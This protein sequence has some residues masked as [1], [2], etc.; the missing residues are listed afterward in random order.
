M[1]VY[2]M[3]LSYLK[4]TIMTKI[5]FFF[6][7][8][9]FTHS[10]FSQTT[11]NPTGS[12]PADRYDDVYFVSPD[13][14]WAVG[15]SLGAGRI[16]HTTNGGATWQVQKT[17]NSY[18]R[19]IEFADKN[20][21]Y[22]GALGQSSTNVL[23][24][25]SDGG[26]NW[27]NISSA[28]T[29]T[30]RG[31]CGICCVNTSITYAVGVWSSPAYVIKSIDGGTTWTY[32][33]MSAYAKDLIDVQFTDANNGYVTGE[34]NV[35]AEGAVILKTTD[36]GSTWSKVFTS[37][38]PGE[39][40]WKIQNL[41]GQNWFGC[42]ESA[43]PI[44][45]P[46]DTVNNMFVKSTDGGNSWIAKP[47]PRSNQFQGIGFMDTQRGWIGNREIFETND[48]GNTWTKLSAYSGYNAFNR[49]QKIN[50]TTAYFSS[51]VVYKLGTATSIKPKIEK[52]YEKWLSV[53]PNPAK[54]DI[55][56]TLDLPHKTMYGVKVYD[57]KGSLIHEEIGERDKG[58]H[59][60]TTGKKLAPGV[61]Y[62]YVMYNEFAEY[63]KVIVE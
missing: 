14:G 50:A 20:I 40:L 19:S 63:K 51:H 43:V 41:D 1:P 31:I 27:T 25:T 5:L 44:L 6:L 22:A 16:Y 35:T 13:T 52:G 56:Y 42:I 55:F 29:G 23:F 21:G 49:F 62:V 59:R 12:T 15:T 8:T 2:V 34:S 60:F 39:R 32:T 47:A 45:N 3:I 48:G 28:I 54:G 58:A 7:T 33:D 18:I 53:Y 26:V 57:A 10:L 37:N 9:A 4:H 11:W 30:N 17:L 46:N 38:G 24:K 36:G 61:Y